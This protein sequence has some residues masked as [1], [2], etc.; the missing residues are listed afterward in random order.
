[1]VLLGACAS[2]QWAKDSGEVATRE[3]ISECSQ[4]AWARARYAQMS[5]PSV[6]AQVLQQDKSGRST[7][8]YDSVRFPQP[9]VQ[10]QNFFNL[11]MREKGY[12]LMPAKTE[13]RR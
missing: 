10:E 13:V 3:I 2:E 9:D 5:N 11:C 12:D 7:A 6:P 8:S 4:Q 1:L